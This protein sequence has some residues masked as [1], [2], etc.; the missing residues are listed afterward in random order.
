MFTGLP[1]NPSWILAT[2]L[3]AAGGVK[4][5]T[6]HR[7]SKTIN[8]LED[9]QFSNHKYFYEWKEMRKG[10]GFLFSMSKIGDQET[11]GL[12][13]STRDIIGYNLFKMSFK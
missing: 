5:A 1:M 13:L 2:V 6:K 7:N 8:G 3:L 4:N 9:R 10:N 12:S 11:K